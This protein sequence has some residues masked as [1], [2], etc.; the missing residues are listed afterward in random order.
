MA[1]RWSILAILLGIFAACLFVATVLSLVLGL[2]LAVQPPNHPETLDLP[3]RLIALQPYRE[4]RWPLDAVSSLLYVVAF[5]ALTLAAVQIAALAGSDRRAGLLQSAILVAGI[6]GVTTGLL[7]I[8]ATK[9]TIDQQYCDCGFKIQESISQF[10]AINIVQGA[11]N[12][13]SYGAIVFSAIALGLSS[14]ALANRGLS[15]AWHVLAWTAAV[16]LVLSIPAHE[17]I[18]SPLGDLLA[19]LATGLLIPAWAILL[20]MRSTDRLSVG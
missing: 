18:D 17:F 15:T 19:A 12:W 4:A 6:L 13:L 2:D 20:A 11:T 7:Y 3:S 8:G 1:K 9:V 10:W 14:L 16:L 5:G